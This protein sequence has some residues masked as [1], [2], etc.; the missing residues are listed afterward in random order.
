MQEGDRSTQEEKTEEQNS[1]AK[2]KTNFEAKRKSPNPRL[3]TEKENLIAGPLLGYFL[4][5]YFLLNYS[6]ASFQEVPFLF[7]IDKSNYLT[8]NIDENRHSSAMFNN[9]MRTK[10]DL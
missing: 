6:L 5:L 2:K 7:F 4:F 3:R 10:S 9:F 1:V 8:K